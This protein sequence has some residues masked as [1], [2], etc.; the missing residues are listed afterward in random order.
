[1]VHSGN[2][3]SNFLVL[4]EGKGLSGEMNRLFLPEG[5][6]AEG[7][8]HMMEALHEVVGVML[9]PPDGVT[10]EKTRSYD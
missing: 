8:W 6:K 5:D 3:N 1:M 4:S 7:W 9:V 2:R 10:K